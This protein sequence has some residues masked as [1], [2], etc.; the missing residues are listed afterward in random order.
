[1]AGGNLNLNVSADL[2][3]SGVEQKINALGQRIA[4]ANKVQFNPVSIKT[5]E[6]L[7]RVTKQY[8]QLLKVHTEL[9]R[10]L[11]QTGQQD[12]ALHEVD[13]DQLYP[14]RAARDRQMR[15]V[16][17]YTFGHSVFSGAGA[18]GGGVGGGGGGGGGHR[19]GDG[20][21]QGTAAQVA[22]AGMR[23]A[24]P[25]GGVAA[26][27]LGTGMSAGFGAGLMG[28]F[29]GMLALGVGK[30]ISTALKYVGKAE[31]HNVGVDTL[32]RV[33]GDVSV[34]FGGLKAVVEATAEN[35]RIT[36]EEATKLSQ[37]FATLGNMKSSQYPTLFDEMQ[38]GVGMSRSFGLD[39][40]EGV[41]VMGRMRGMGVTKDLQDSRRFALLIGE[42]IGKSNAFAKAGEVMEALAGYAENQ[43]RN[44]MGAANAGGFAGQFSAMVGSGIPGLDPAG[45]GSLLSRVNAALTAGGAKG[46]ASQFYTGMLGARMGM[47]PFQTQVFREGGAFATVDEA[48]GDGSVAKRYGMK[49]PKGGGGSETL[50]SM[51]LK[52][53]RKDYGNDPGMLAQAT[54]NH[55]GVNMR[56]AMALLSVEPNKMDEMKKYVPDITK[57][58]GEGILS[59]S[60]VVY[61]S[62]DDRKAVA[63]E[64]RGRTDLTE[65]EKASIDA[66]EKKGDGELKK[67]LAGLVASKDQ[68]QTTGKDVRD[69]KNALE[70]IKT[71]IA[72]KLVPYF[73]EA[74]LGIMYL[75]GVKDKKTT[76][77]VMKDVIRNDS[78]GRERAIKG[79]FETEETGLTKRQ[80]N[81]RERLTGGDLNERTIGL[82]TMGR[83][84]ALARKLEERKKAMDELKAVEERLKN[85]QEEKAELLKK[86]NERR[87]RELAEIDAEAQRRA[88]AEAEGTPGSMSGQNGGG[89]M[90]SS[91]GRGGRVAPAGK[92]AVQSAMK[93]FMG[94]GWSETAAAGIVSNLVAESGLQRDAVGD[95][96]LAYGLAQ[97]HPARQAEFKKVFGKDIRE[98]TA[99]EQMAFVNHELKNGKY[100]NAGRMLAGAKDKKQAAGIVTQYY[101]IPSD[102]PGESKRRGDYA[103]SLTPLPAGAPAGAAGPQNLGRVTS[104][105][106]EVVLKNEKGQ[107]MAPRQSIPT[108]VDRPRPLGATG[109]W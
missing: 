81:L 43:T 105:P 32:K 65:K 90:G 82:A 70:N 74:R 83:P 85:L 77:D 22:Q 46:E 6:Q 101:E 71:S 2:D 97:W 78:E 49:A 93:Y 39:P 27:A 53:L 20:S 35:M 33:L 103:E 56:Q 45:A 41:G 99:E 108:K 91:Q 67:V 94:Q 7:Q 87:A 14:N 104:D 98:S 28:L 23:A 30:A 92:E 21:W 66:A 102:I 19:P 57:L 4:Q 8:E 47:D 17:E 29:G 13:F 37:S 9:N 51:T 107:E 50:L 54:A 76:D 40:S 11:K 60:K 24:G 52:Q 15:N 68:E 1:M 72:D 31:N 55:L 109:R 12:R 73:N 25:V 84:D 5:A 75:A 16:Y 58:N 61:G 69:S 79:R 34:S 42:T 62:A 96:G 89:K 3:T 80:F 63:N 59:L 64:L 86:E 88:M 95:G 10:R 18:G 38:L 36:Y 26:N 106:I 44:N 100:Q 48:F